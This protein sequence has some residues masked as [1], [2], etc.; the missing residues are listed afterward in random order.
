[1]TY[2]QLK[3]VSISYKEEQSEKAILSDVN[4]DIDKGTFSTVLGP[5]G[6]G[7]TTLLKAIAGISPIVKGEI[8]LDNRSIQNIDV[9][10]REI[11]YVPQDPTLFQHL[12]VFDNIA[13]GLRI[14]KIPIA[15]IKDR[16]EELATIAGINDILYKS[17]TKI[18]GGQAQRV[19]LCRALA[20]DPRLLLLDEP[21]SALDSSLRIRLALDVRRIQRELGITTLHVTHDQ[22]EARLI[23][24]QL[25]VIFNKKIVQVSSKNT[26]A[27]L[28]KNWEIAIILGYTNVIEPFLYNMLSLPSNYSMLYPNG[29]FLDPDILLIS[30]KTNTGIKGR[31]IDT[32]SG[33]ISDLPSLISLKN[34]PISKQKKNKVWVH[35]KVLS[36]EKTLYILVNTD[37]EYNYLDVVQLYNITEAFVPFK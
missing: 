21:L 11:G 22:R 18:S 13:F 15:T 12:S 3:H 24:D 17:S 37:D 19:S 33:A 2:L 26:I 36:E 31:I 16:V 35:L 32:Y 23:S 5:S 34:A 8:L 29:G 1:M 20:F 10:R 30:K 28:P 7:K 14:R 25:I 6:C 9:H 27:N 4:L